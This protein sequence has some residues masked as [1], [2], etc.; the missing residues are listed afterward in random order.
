MFGQYGKSDVDSEFLG[1]LVIPWKGIH[2][3]DAFDVGG[4]A[5]ALR[6]RC[7]LA[8]TSNPQSYQLEHD[9]IYDTMPLDNLY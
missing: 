4:M 3:R 8:T 6:L 1:R 9:Y 2:V 5:L 7:K